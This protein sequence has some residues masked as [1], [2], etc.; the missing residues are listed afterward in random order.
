MLSKTISVFFLLVISFSLRAQ[1]EDVFYD[2]F[3]S[4][5]IN[6]GKKRSKDVRRKII[7]VNI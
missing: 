7:G 3:S 6:G 2:D 1:K 4:N 5:K